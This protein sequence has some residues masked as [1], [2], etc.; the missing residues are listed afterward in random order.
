ML[1]DQKSASSFSFRRKKMRQRRRSLKILSTL[2][3]L[4]ALA[5]SAVHWLGLRQVRKSLKL[6]LQG[7]HLEAEQSGGLWARFPTLSRENRELQ[8]LAALARN[9]YE[10]GREILAQLKKPGRFLNQESILA[11]FLKRS[12]YR[13]LE[14]WLTHLE[15][16]SADYLNLYWAI[17]HSAMFNR[18]A[19]AEK[20]AELSPAGR[21]KYQRRIDLLEKIGA[22]LDQDRLDFVFDRN[23][24]PLA[25]YKP[26]TREIQA[27]LPG[28]SFAPLAGRIGQGLN[29]FSL[30]LDRELQNL[31]HRLFGNMK[32]SFVLLDLNDFGLLACYSRPESGD[33]LNSAL[34]EPYYPASVTKVLSLLTY[35]RHGDQRLFP[36]ECRGNLS[37]GRS[38]FY[39]WTSHGSVADPGRALVVSCNTA[40]AE[41]IFAAG[42]TAYQD[43]LHQFFFNAPDLN[44]ELFTIGFGGFETRQRDRFDLAN[45][46][47]GLREIRVTTI[48]AALIAGL[49]ATG[50]QYSRP[51]LLLNGRNLFDLAWFHHQPEFSPRIDDQQSFRYLH[52]A[53]AEVVNSAEGTARRAAGSPL[54]PAVKTGTIGSSR[55]AFDAILIGFFP[56]ERPAYAFA[57]RLQGAGKAELV[58]APFLKRFLD[59]FA[60]L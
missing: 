60:R 27:D 41:M 30:S 14:T 50:G 21:Q 15:T 48:H 38:I 39:D 33:A 11:L 5:V 45:L 36:Y 19:A 34:A 6:H 3:I 46:A 51:F 37:F 20:L 54:H 25:A 16:K 8:A 44:E 42:E 18:Q 58:G 12:D 43:L 55:T 4:L 53:M 56:L 1:I 29:Y 23:G 17:L 13:S 57:F 31:V 9:D 26:S 32:G 47:V 52:Q 7:L 24:R 22:E 49:I 2:L 59:E 28:F 35:L 40:F 10:Q